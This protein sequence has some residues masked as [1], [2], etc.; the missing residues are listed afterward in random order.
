[1]KNVR[2]LL[3]IA[4]CVCPANLVVA[5]PLNAV[6]VATSYPLYCQG[7][8]V[9]SAGTTPLTAFKWSSEGA[10]AAS[11]GPG[12]CAW[13]DRGPRGNEIQS[14]YGNVISGTLNQA[15]NLPAGQY[16]KIRVHHD[17]DSDAMVVLQVGL[18]TPPF[19]AAPEGVHAYVPFLNPVKL[20]QPVVPEAAQEISSVVSL[21]V[22]IDA[23]GRVIQ[24]EALTGPEALRQLAGDAVK[25]R[26]YRPVLRYGVPVSAFTDAVVGFPVIGK[27]FARNDSEGMDSQ[28]RREAL[29]SSL[30]RSRTQI[31][32]DLEQDA[33]GGDEARRFSAL[34]GMAKAAFEAGVTEK[35]AAYANEV[36]VAATQHQKEWN[37]GN[38]IHDGNLVLGLLAVRQGNIEE[39]DKYLLAAGKTPGSPQL[40]SFGPDMSLAK[41]LLEHDERE[42]VMEYFSQCRTFWK[43]GTQQLDEWTEIVRGGGMPDFR[44]NLHLGN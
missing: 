8:L 32:A 26:I 7:P 3:L 30:P 33:G 11:P 12:E 20:V 19:S 34:G 5:E 1:M 23:A 6:P 41:A 4:L 37:Y 2:Q 38:A 15:A 18:V 35:A 40:N 9:T 14:D 27:P 25:Q 10:G 29:K 24:T 13:A 22:T 39:A 43:M 21:I 28:R 31:L 36:L 17:P 42:A 44:S 16:V